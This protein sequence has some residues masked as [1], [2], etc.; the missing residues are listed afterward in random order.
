MKT[1]FTPNSIVE[2][3]DAL[4][5]YLPDGRLFVAK[6]INNSNLR[7]LLVSVSGEYTRLQNKIYEVSTEYDLENTTNLINEWESA[8]GIPDTAFTKDT[9][10][11]QRRKQIVAKFALMNLTVDADWIYLAAFFGYTIEIRHGFNYGVFPITF[12]WIFFGDAK[13]AKFTM[14]IV[15][16]GLPQPGNVFPIVFPIVFDK[17]TNF[18]INLFKKLK[19]ANVN[20]K[21]LWEP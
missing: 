13:S 8:L 6:N 2:N 15:F 14:V 3:A 11:V 17:D 18:L 1:N 20:I 12:P 21:F 5:A 16:K 7:N 4:G 19:P 9:D 10:I